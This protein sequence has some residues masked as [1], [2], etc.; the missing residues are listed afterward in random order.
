MKFPD[1]DIYC[2]VIDNYGDIGFTNSLA[3]IYRA[4]HPEA[5]VRIFFDG[6][7]ESPEK[8]AP[9]VVEIFGSDIPSE[10]FEIIKRDAHLWINVEYLTAE[11][12]IE[13]CHGKESIIPDC[14]LRK[15][16]FMPG[17]T[18]RTGGILMD[19][20][21]KEEEKNVISIF[22]YDQDFSS[23][24]EAFSKFPSTEFLIF[25]KYSQK[26]FEGVAPKYPQ[27]KFTISPF[28]TA[29]EYDKVLASSKINFVRGEQ[30]FIRTILAGKPFIW[31]AYIQEGDYQL[32]KVEAFLDVFGKYWENKELF[33]VYRQIML[34]WNGNKQSISVDNWGIFIEN[35]PTIRVYTQNFANYLRKECDLGSHFDKF[36]EELW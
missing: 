31:Q 26:I 36:I 1:M 23:M 35:L 28:L 25:D 19:F 15:Y 18:E 32:V 14:N 17:F 4:H 9:L 3:D 20:N 12:W 13:D 30:S 2:Q 27:H 5:K 8:S 7:P 34:A 11:K 29:D 21:A 6:E 33:E 22:T 16:F 24:L 10:H